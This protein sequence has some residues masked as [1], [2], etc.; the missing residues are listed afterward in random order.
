MLRQRRILGV[1]AAR[2]WVARLWWLLS[3]S[4]SSSSG[5]PPNYSLSKNLRLRGVIFSLEV[6]VGASTS[7][8]GKAGGGTTPTPVPGPDNVYDT[9]REIQGIA[10][11]TSKYGDKLRMR[12]LGL[13]AG[14]GQAD[15]PRVKGDAHLLR[16]SKM[17]AQ[18]QEKAGGGDGGRWL[19]QE[20]MGNVLDYTQVTLTLH[21]LP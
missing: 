4:H 11:I 14:A 1:V 15:T 16:A 7:S 5:H 17:A 19:L 6:L 21:F 12:G 13:G 9:S 8:S 3:A 2:P 10:T 18:Q 20:G